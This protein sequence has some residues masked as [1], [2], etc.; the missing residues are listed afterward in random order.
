[1]LKKLMAVLHLLLLQEPIFTLEP[2]YNLMPEISTNIDQP[3]TIIEGSCE[4]L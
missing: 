4:S 3:K 1:M 2:H